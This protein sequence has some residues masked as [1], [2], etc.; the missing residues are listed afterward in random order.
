MMHLN[1]TAKMF[2]NDLP[3]LAGAGMNPDFFQMVKMSQ[4]EES[5]QFRK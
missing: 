3:R 5:Q 4:K 2:T 1:H